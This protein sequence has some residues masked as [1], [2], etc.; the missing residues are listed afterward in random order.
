MR[1]SHCGALCG[2]PQ[3]THGLS[4]GWD[5][6]GGVVAA[7]ISWRMG[8]SVRWRLSLLGSSCWWLL[9]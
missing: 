9:Q 4:G 7:R 3:L 8:G 5:V 1:L 2:P 6:G